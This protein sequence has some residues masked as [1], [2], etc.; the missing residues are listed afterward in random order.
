LL[1]IDF[2]K[3]AL[4]QNLPHGNAKFKIALYFREKSFP[5]PLA[6][7]RVFG[8]PYHKGLT[9]NVFFGQQAPVARILR[10]EHVVARYEVVIFF[11]RV[12]R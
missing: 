5:P 3:R 6:R 7:A 10:V 1:H 9:H 4:P 8:L 12:R 2:T 11:E